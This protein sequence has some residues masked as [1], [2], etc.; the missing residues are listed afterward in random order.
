MTIVENSDP[1][2]R[3]GVGWRLADR[4]TVDIG[5]QQHDPNYQLFRVA[6]AIRLSDG[7]IVIANA[8]TQ[9]LRFYDPDG[10][11]DATTGGAGDGPGEFRNIG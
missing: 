10:M 4:P 8:G 11:Y 1:V 3:E 2:R 9:E 5:E 6:S 7:R